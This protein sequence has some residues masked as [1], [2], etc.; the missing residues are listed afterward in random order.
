MLSSLSISGCR[1]TLSDDSL[2][3]KLLDLT[4]NGDTTLYI[5][6]YDDVKSVH[7]ISMNGMGVDFFTLK[8]EPDK[9]D[10]RWE[11]DIEVNILLRI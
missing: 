7:L 9:D 6:S 4:E 5:D 2:F 11:V 1:T 8:G 3:L 10:G